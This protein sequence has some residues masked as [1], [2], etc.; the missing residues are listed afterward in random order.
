MFSKLKE[1]G[2]VSANINEEVSKIEKKIIIKQNKQIDTQTI[3]KNRKQR[4]K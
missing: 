3:T 2:L 4:R 1:I